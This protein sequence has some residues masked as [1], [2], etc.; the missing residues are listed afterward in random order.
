MARWQR[1][2]VPD[3]PEQRCDIADRLAEDDS[4]DCERCGGHGHCACYHAACHHCGSKDH[5]SATHGTLA[6]HDR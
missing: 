5:G 3:F 2:P 1:Q 4:Q 6:G